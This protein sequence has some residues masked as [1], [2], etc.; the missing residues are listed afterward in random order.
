MGLLGQM[1]LFLDPRGIATPSFTM[2]ELIYTP[3]NS[4]KP[5]YFS[6]FS[7]AS[8]VSRFFN[9]HHSNWCEMV[10]QNGFDLHFSNDQG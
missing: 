2:V 8:V 3:T 1:V 10:S 6:T 5:S 4:E 7:L 9:D